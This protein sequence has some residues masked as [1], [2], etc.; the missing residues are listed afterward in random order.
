MQIFILLVAL[1]SLLLVLINKFFAM[2]SPSLHK[3]APFECGFSS[4]SQTRNPFDINFYIVGL[5]FLIFDLEILLIYPFALSFSIYGF[6][7]L[8]IFLILLTIGFV[9]ELAKGV[10]KF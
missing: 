5:L 4:F 1:L 9:Y 8:M 6:Y 3:V 10:I 2:T 7:I